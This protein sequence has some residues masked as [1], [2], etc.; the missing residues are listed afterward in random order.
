MV[1]QYV[2]SGPSKLILNM[3]REKIEPIEQR[4]ESAMSL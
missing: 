2:S 4:I 1:Y 3:Y